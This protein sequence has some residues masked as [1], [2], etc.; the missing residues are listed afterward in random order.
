MIRRYLFLFA[1]LIPCWSSAQVGGTDTLRWTVSGFRDL[2]TSVDVVSPSE[3]IISGSEQIKWIQDGGNFTITWNVTSVVG[4]W[5]NLNEAGS[6]TFHFA[7]ELVQGTLITSRTATGLSIEL[8]MTGGP[9]PFHLKFSV[10]NVQ[11]Q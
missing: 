7:D 6:Q 1:I 2:N 5:G 3:F 8:S 4:T 9:S 10:V 11:K